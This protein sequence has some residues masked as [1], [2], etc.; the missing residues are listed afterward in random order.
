M[1]SDISSAKGNDTHGHYDGLED[2]H[3]HLNDICVPENQPRNSA[4]SLMLERLEM[5]LSFGN[6]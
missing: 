1:L 5:M 6:R 4:G 3:M 2:V